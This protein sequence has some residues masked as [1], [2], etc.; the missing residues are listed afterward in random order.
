VVLG[1]G[2]CG[3]AWGRAKRGVGVQTSE[4]T[5][6]GPAKPVGQRGAFVAELRNSYVAVGTF[7]GFDLTRNAV[8]APDYF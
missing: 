1:V 7:A 6:T 8:S 4:D 2:I 5:T 3:F